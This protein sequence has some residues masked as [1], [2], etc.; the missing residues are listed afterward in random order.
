MHASLLQC[1]RHTI[2]TTASGQTPSSWSNLRDLHV[3]SVCNNFGIII[4]LFVAQRNNILNKIRFCH[5]NLIFHLEWSSW[6]SYISFTGRDTTAINLQKDLQLAVLCPTFNIL[7]TLI[8]QD[9]ESHRLYWLVTAT[10]S[11]VISSVSDSETHTRSVT[12]RLK[13]A[14][15]SSPNTE[16]L[17]HNERAPSSRKSRSVDNT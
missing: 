10:R 15:G 9:D 2:A 16:Q 11:T 12:Q 3:V 13:L 8:S 5:A 1:V 6:D 7:C 14:M 4:Y 17:G